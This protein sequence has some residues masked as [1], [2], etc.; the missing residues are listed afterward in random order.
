MPQGDKAHLTYTSH[1]SLSDTFRESSHTQLRL[2]LCLEADANR[3]LI[4]TTASQL[5]ISIYA[6]VTVW[7][8]IMEVRGDGGVGEGLFRRH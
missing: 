7:L 4:L 1:G 5:S 6:Q 3:R 2:Q 8:E